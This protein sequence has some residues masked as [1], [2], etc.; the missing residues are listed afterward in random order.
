MATGSHQGFLLPFQRK[1]PAHAG[2]ERINKYFSRARE[3]VEGETTVNDG[4][5]RLTTAA[6]I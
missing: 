3:G 2:L 1:F 4:G 6:T 5:H